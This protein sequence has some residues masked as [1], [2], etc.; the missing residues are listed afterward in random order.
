MKKNVIRLKHVFTRKISFH[1]LTRDDDGEW[2]VGVDHSGV[3][4]K[5]ARLACDHNASE[6]F[7][8]SR[9]LTTVDHTNSKR[10]SCTS[11]NQRRRNS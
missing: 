6:A 1:K 11:A 9:R 4:V 2:C 5:G 10:T 3:N 8:D 7:T